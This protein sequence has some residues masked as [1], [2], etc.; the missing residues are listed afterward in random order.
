MAVHTHNAAFAKQSED[1]PR[2][3]PARAMTMIMG[4]RDRI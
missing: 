4:Q 3:Y 2:G 1:T